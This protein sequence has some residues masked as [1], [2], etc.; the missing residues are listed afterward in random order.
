VQV[1]QVVQPG[2]AQ[3]DQIPYSAPLLVQAADMEI[4]V[5]LA[6]LVVLA[7]LEAA[8]FAVAQV[9]LGTRQALLHLKAIM[10]GLEAQTPN[11]TVYL[12]VAAGP[13]KPEIQT[14]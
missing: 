12:A 13:E 6:A 2:L 7:V 3:L 8:L 9:A 10:V 1:A 5:Q 14:D 4:L 11:Q